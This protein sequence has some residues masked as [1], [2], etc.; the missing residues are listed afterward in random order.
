M[1]LS[2]DIPLDVL[3]YILDWIKLPDLASF[4]RTSKKLYP[5]ARN[6]LYRHLN[7]TPEK[8]VAAFSALSK[9]PTLSAKVKSLVLSGTG[10]EVVFGTIQDILMLMPQLRTLVLMISPYGSWTLPQ[11]NT[12]P[13]QLQTFKCNFRYDWEL[14]NFL[15][16]Q[17]RLRHLELRSHDI[18]EMP[19]M[20]LT[21]NHLPLLEYIS[22]P[23]PVVFCL[24]PKRPIQQVTIYPNPS[25]D[26]TSESILD[27]LSESTAKNGVQRLFLSRENLYAARNRL[28]TITPGLTHLTLDSRSIDPSQESDVLFPQWMKDIVSHLRCLRIFTIKLEPD[29]SPIPCQEIDFIPFV[30][31]VFQA[32]SSLEYVIIT[33]NRLR[34]RYT[35]KRIQGKDDWYLCDDF[36]AL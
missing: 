34:A 13:F 21:T 10:F 3:D 36:E 12:S 19:L 7:L 17:Q 35:C 22:A 29:I 28:A 18:V 23:W 24:V 1:P 14:E 33:F 26:T 6:A 2:T 30:T 9:E 8:I 31:K 11:N 4:C 20:K 5:H 15:T 32:A 27:C 25:R 16:S